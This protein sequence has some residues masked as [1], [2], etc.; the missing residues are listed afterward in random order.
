[1]KDVKDIA[2]IVQARLSSER[3]PGKMIKPFADTTL[4]DIACEKVLNSKV[5]PKENFYL[6][7]YDDVLVD[8]GKKHGINIYHRSEASA[9]SEGPM[10]EVMEWHDR[11]PHKYVVMISA[12]CPLLKTETIDSFVQ[13]YLDSEHRGMFAVIQK[14]NYFWNSNRDLITEWPKC[15]V[16]DTKRVGVTY[17]AAHCLYAGRMD[18]IKDSI[19]MGEVPFTKDDPVIHVVDEEEVFDIDYPWQF[20]V[21]EALYKEKR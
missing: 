1:M 2:F 21:A 4:V 12:C 6:S 20:T 15:D 13:A 17:E 11:L 7:V 18:L 14:K 16:L 8:I 3:L 19:W 10:Q 9:L 5:I